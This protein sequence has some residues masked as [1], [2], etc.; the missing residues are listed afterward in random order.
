MISFEKAQQIVLDHI[1]ILEPERIPVIESIGMTLAED[2]VSGFDIPPADMAKIGGFAIRSADATNSGQRTP[3]SLIIDGDVKAGDNWQEV[4]KSGHA[5]RVEAGA[6]LPEGTDTIIPTDNAVRENSRK[7]NIY[8]QEK[9]GEHISMRGVEIEEGELVFKKGKVL[10][11]TDTGVLAALGTTE[12]LCHRRPKVSFFASGNDL[13]APDEPV[14]KGKMRSANIFAIQAH[15]EEFGSISDN[16]GIIGVDQESIKERVD[17]A[18]N[19]DMLIVSTGSSPDVFDKVKAVL[20]KLGMDLKFWKVAIRPGKP[21]AFGVINNL[22]VFGVSENQLSTAV[23]MEEFIRPVILKMGGRR[24]IRRTEVVA[25][26][27]KE[28]KCGSGKTHFICAEIRLLDN[29][30]LAIPENNRHSTSIRAFTTANGFIIIPP[31][32]G[33]IEAGEMVRVQIIGEPTDYN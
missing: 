21:L 27:D 33:F 31:D 24:D 25:R 16:M 8:K 18:I 11:P 2:I 7:V 30:F 26:L 12:V 3:A 13:V 19:S 32:I 9:P 5:V 28:I 15:L 22:P 20:Q 6:P 17:R 23:V 14:N 1:D 10:N 4:V 29:G